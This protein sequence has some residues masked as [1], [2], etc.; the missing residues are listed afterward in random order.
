MLIDTHTHLYSD[1][2]N[3]DR[4]AVMQRSFDKNIHHFFLP[5]IDAAHTKSMH[6]LK[7]AYPK[8]IHLMMGLH[9]TLNMALSFLI[10]HM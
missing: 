6:D 10:S 8:N 9:P 4:D 5:A 3:D 1:A 2:F 7:A